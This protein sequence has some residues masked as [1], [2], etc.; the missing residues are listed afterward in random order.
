MELLMEFKHLKS[1]VSLPGTGVQE[2]KTRQAPAVLTTTVKPCVCCPKSFQNL[3]IGLD[4][5]TR[6]VFVVLSPF[7]PGP[8]RVLCSGLWR[9]HGKGQG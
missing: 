4:S 3:E 2:V 8:P 7:I 6:Q 9:R 1:K 5:N